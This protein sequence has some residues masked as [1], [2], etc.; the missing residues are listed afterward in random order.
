MRRPLPPFPHLE[1]GLKGSRTTPTKCRSRSYTPY[2]LELTL[3]AMSSAVAREIELYSGKTSGLTFEAFDEKVITWCRK[4]C[5]DAYGIGLWKNELDDIYNLD[6]TDEE[7]NFSFELQCAKVYD[8]LYR[9]S[10]KKNADWLH[11]KSSF[12][13]KKY[14]VEFRQSC[15]KQVFC[16]LEELCTGE[17]ARQ[18]RKQGVRKMTTMR[19]S[20]FQR[21]GAGQ[22]ELSN[23]G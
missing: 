12:W 8:V 9:T 3:Q 14:R 17:A 4:K 21:F 15:R 20:F 7:D 22:P 5:G 13:T 1:C 23:Q 6:L 10:V 11:A 2:D 19:D 18:L 16:Y